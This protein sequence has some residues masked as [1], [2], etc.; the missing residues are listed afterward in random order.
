MPKGNVKAGYSQKSV[1]MLE[2]TRA[3]NTIS[4]IVFGTLAAAVAIAALAY[5][6]GSWPEAWT[7]QNFHPSQQTLLIVAG[8]AAFFMLLCLVG[9]IFNGTRWRTANQIKRLSTDARFS[10]AMPDTAL[11][12]LRPSADPPPELAVTFVPPR[13]V[14]KIRVRLQR[15]TAD[16]NIVGHRPLHIVYLRL[17]DNQPRMRT[18]I[19]G[20]W[21]EFGYVHLLRSATSVTRAELRTAKSSGDV[22]HLFVKNP[23]EFQTALAQL[24]REPTPKG[25]HT[26][27]RLGPTTIKVRDPY[28]S[29]PVQGTLCHG[30]FWKEAVDMLLDRADL[31]VIDLS[32]Y[33]DA[34]EG[35]RYEVQRVVD[36]M[37]IERVVF[38]EDE[39]SKNKFLE[40]ELKRAWNSMLPTSP[41][42]RPTPCTA[43]V[44][45]TDRF[46][47]SSTDTGSGQEQVHIR[48][49]AQRRPSRRVV[50]A[51]QDRLERSG[52]MR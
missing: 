36:R 18:F 43:V 33:T 3:A 6:Q 4:A 37:P 42:R 17:F 49:I 9:A 12:A 24:P 27:K 29:Y 23:A 47:R 19:Q 25:R 34:N 20:A 13:K 10:A 48:L 50:A 16:A 15:V 41:N 32:G 2:P 26:F 30:G 11:P 14:P 7:P 39:R 40:F 31:A 44:F 45:Q 22:S 46:Q 51:A 38:L 52:S 8:V 1:L 28:G 5:R 35:T 21:R